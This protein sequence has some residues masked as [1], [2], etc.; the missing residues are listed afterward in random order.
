ML[1]EHMRERV[2]RDWTATKSYISNLIES[3]PFLGEE[4]GRTATHQ[5]A[6]IFLGAMS[7]DQFLKAVRCSQVRGDCVRNSSWCVRGCGEIAKMRS[8]RCDGVQRRLQTIR[9]AFRRV[10][11]DN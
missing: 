8:R 6:I 11:V 1:A 4:Y 9:Y 10:G 7:F 5:K 2:V 3:F